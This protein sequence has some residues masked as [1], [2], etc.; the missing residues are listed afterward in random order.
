M[1]KMGDFLKTWM[2]RMSKE[3]EKFLERKKQLWEVVE[4]NK[5]FSCDNGII[6][7]EEDGIRYEWV[8]DD[9]LKLVSCLRRKGLL[10]SVFGEEFVNVTTEKLD[11]KALEV[12]EKFD[13]DK[14]L[15]IIG[16]L[17]TGKTSF[18][19]LLLIKAKIL[20]KNV[21]I[22]NPNKLLKDY[23]GGKDDLFMKADVLLID[24]LGIEYNTDAFRSAFEE[25]IDYRWRNR[26]STAITS[27]F[28]VENLFERYPRAMDRLQ[29][30]GILVVLKGTSLRR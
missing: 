24:D 16:P 11:E 13:F 1:E 7:Y 27:N 29:Q 4:K 22:R 2:D 23:F 25:I 20:S 9:Y 19:A 8:C 30:R 26:K 14:D 28:E 15:I 17:G 12:Y 3:R 21:I 10:L 18:L 5:C 6:F